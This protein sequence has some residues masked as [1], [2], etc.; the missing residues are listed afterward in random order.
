[1][2]AQALA[3][4]AISLASLD[5]HLSDRLDWASRFASATAHD[6][7]NIALIA[8]M[9]RP[10]RAVLEDVD[11]MDGL[12]KQVRCAIGSM[13]VWRSGRAA[14][15]RQ[16]TLKDWWLQHGRMV[17]QFLPP[18]ARMILANPADDWNIDA[19][20]LCKALAGVFVAMEAQI[21]PLERVAV[22]VQPCS[23]GAHACVSIEIFPGAVPIHFV[24]PTL[25]CTLLKP[26]SNVIVEPESRTIQL[27]LASNAFSSACNNEVH[28]VKR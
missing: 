7:G 19:V 16:C 11:P 2:N 25:V 4:Q 20:V 9:L 18:S 27:Q 10:Q 3:H 8:S 21:K 28:P 17:R 15:D 1:M 23:S 22:S 5:A 13:D 24:I 14:E 6:L 12:V 26:G